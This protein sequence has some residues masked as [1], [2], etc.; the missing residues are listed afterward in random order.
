MRSALEWALDPANDDEVARIRSAAKTVARERF[1][2]ENYLAGI[3]EIADALLAQGP[4][5]G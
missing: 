1:G 3:L 5:R 4:P 2:P